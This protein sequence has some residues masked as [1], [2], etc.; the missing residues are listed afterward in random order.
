MTVLCVSLASTL[1]GSST[2]WAAGGDVLWHQSA[3]GPAHSYD[4]GNS[5]VVSPDGSRVY[6]AGYVT[7]TTTQENAVVKAYEAVS[8]DPV[9]TASYDGRAHRTDMFQDAVLSPDGSVLYVTG[10]SRGVDTDLDI[11]T[12]AIST[13]S[14]AKV[15]VSRLAGPGRSDDRP[16]AIAVDPTGTRVFV[17]GYGSGLGGLATAYSATTGAELWNWTNGSAW[18]FDVGVGAGGRVVIVGK[19]KGD[20]YIAARRGRTGVALWA[21]RAGGA[22]YEVA[23]HLALTPDG[24]TAFMGGWIDDGTTGDDA[25]VQAYDVAT[26]AKAWGRT[27]DGASHGTDHV[28]ALAAGADGASVYVSNGSYPDDG[29]LQSLSAVDGSPDWSVAT[30][31]TPLELATGPAG[32]VSGMAEGGG[33][34]R[35]YLATVYD[36]T[37]G[38]PGWTGTWASSSGNP[39]GM[40]VAPDGSAVFVTGGAGDDIT[41]IAFGTN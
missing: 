18:V 29:W 41:T 10:L 39:E 31:D 16:E 5:V 32:F 12:E 27:Y 9:W 24:T 40:A 34:G 28:W 35:D 36:A 37:T 22:G 25:L 19:M 11:V 4:S 1:L 23:E 33:T 13:S 8:G 21:H 20:D 14:G 3:D 30:P 7:G 17:G 2:A 15:W 6:V 38:A 26:G